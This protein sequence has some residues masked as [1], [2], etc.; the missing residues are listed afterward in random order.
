MRFSIGNVTRRDDVTGCRL[1]FF[2]PNNSSGASSS[3][4]TLLD[5]HPLIP[6]TDTPGH[7]PGAVCSPVGIA[8]G[9]N[10]FASLLL[11]LLLLMSACQLRPQMMNVS[12]R[13]L[14]RAT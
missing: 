11:L 4:F 14:L 12:C 7:Q 2:C 13:C 3:H 6:S 9:T 5:G 10:D 1:I 8:N